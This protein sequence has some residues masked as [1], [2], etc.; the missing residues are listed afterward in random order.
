MTLEPNTATEA[1]KILAIETSTSLLGVA[2]VVG[3]RVLYEEAI[4]KPRVHS[5]MLLPMCAMALEKTRIR[6]MDLDAVAVSVG[7][8]SF[9]GLRIGCATAQ[10]LAHAWSK[11]VVPVST[12][13][14]LLEQVDREEVVGEAPSY[15]AVVQ[16]KARAQ[17]VTAL[18]AGSSPSGRAP[19]T[20]PGALTFREVILPGARSVEEFLREFAAIP[21]R[22]VLVTGDAAG[23]FRDYYEQQGRIRFPGHELTLVD[24]SA[25][26]PQ[27]RSVAA[28]G[29]RMFLDGLSSAPQ[30]A[31]P[32]YFR[33]SQAEAV[34]ARKSATHE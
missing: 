17:T 11:P 9:T 10:G 15:V 21:Q 24:D 18:Y 1:V 29:A 3:D 7:P 34:M 27:P 14:V 4:V 22:R 6:P 23:E 5:S 26:L 13:L 25:R 31:I 33:K 20:L 32:R 28:I 2:V 19:G 8:G 12:F 30:A 16:G